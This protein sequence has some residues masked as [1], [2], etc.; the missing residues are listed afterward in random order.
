[1]TVF[2]SETAARRF[3]VLEAKRPLRGRFWPLQKRNGAL[4]IYTQRILRVTN[5]TAIPQR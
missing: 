1:V 3:S 2:A 5:V 4:Q